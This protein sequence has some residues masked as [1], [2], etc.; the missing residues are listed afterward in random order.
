[1]SATNRN[2]NGLLEYHWC[3]VNHT[4]NVTGYHASWYSIKA[5]VSN[6]H[7]IRQMRFAKG[8]W[9]MDQRESPLKFYC[10]KDENFVSDMPL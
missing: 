10:S 5:E 6:G 3:C 7:Y 8:P 4:M 2:K 9:T 1:M